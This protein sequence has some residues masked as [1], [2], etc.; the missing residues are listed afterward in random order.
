MKL[1]NP[2]NHP[3]LF[4]LLT[5]LSAARLK[6]HELNLSTGRNQDRASRWSRKQE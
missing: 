5:L 6:L 3:G 1:N 2:F 4:D